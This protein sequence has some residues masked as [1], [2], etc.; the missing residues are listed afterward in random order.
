VGF[1]LPRFVF[2]LPFLVQE[3][4]LL[5][6]SL[7]CLTYFPFFFVPVFGREHPATPYE[8]PLSVVGLFF[9]LDVDWNFFLGVRVTMF[10]ECQFV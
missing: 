10:R 8:Q 5:F 2:A 6:W 3:D 7:L 1:F 4:P 9:L